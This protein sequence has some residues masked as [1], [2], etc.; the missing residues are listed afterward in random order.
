L[1]CVVLCCV[2]LC[3]VVLC[4]V[5]L[6]CVVL[7]CVVLCCVVLCC[8]VLSCVVAVRN[9][10]R[11]NLGIICGAVKYTSHITRGNKQFKF[12]EISITGYLAL[13]Q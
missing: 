7:C 13:T 8:V 12:L 5:V 9:H 1:C 3:C 4:C 2:V 6:C 11:S 10:L